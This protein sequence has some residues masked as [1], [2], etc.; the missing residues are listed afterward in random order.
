[1]KTN[2]SSLSS[3][4]SDVFVAP[5]NGLHTNYLPSPVLCLANT[6]P[7]INV[8]NII[9]QLFALGKNRFVRI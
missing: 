9:H 8:S 3:T 2:F 7:S 5:D 1:M 6:K 4:K